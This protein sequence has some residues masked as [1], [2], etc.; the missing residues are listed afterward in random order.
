MA[1]LLIDRKV[2][3]WL[4][5][6][7]YSKIK[8]L[9]DSIYKSIKHKEYKKLK[10]QMVLLSQISYHTPE[11]LRKEDVHVELYQQLKCSNISDQEIS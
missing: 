8:I 3:A 2:Q 10:L 11:F 7:D 5:K 1:S 4:Q 9:I 6:D